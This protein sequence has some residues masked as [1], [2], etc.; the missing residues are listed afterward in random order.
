MFVYTKLLHL[1]CYKLDKENSFKKLHMEFCIILFVHPSIN[2]SISSAISSSVHSLVFPY[3]LWSFVLS[4]LAAL[5]LWN[6][7]KFCLYGWNSNTQ[8]LTDTSE[9]VGKFEN[10]KKP[11]FVFQ[12]NFVDQK[13]TW[14]RHLIMI[15]K[16]SENVQITLV[17]TLNFFTLTFTE[18]KRWSDAEKWDD[19]RD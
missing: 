10:S 4:I 7:V 15:I 9:K 8:K 19:S 11:C 14:I 18:N 3:G 16:N 17:H 5:P 12:Q 1:V 13:N 2:S 6:N